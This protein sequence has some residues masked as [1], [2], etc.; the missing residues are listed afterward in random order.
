MSLSSD[1]ESKSSKDF[2]DL[3]LKIDQNQRN[4]QALD[5]YDSLLIEDG[6]SHSKNHLQVSN[7]TRKTNDLSQIDSLDRDVIEIKAGK[8][9][10]PGDTASRS[11]Q[12]S[13]FVIS[14]AK[15]MDNLAAK[16]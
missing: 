5:A 10:A 16:A 13:N 14:K 11:E 1:S 15:P 12:S 3:V 7:Q 6:D 9:V 8:R 2:T 4:E